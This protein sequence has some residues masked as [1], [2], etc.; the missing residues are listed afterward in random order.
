MSKCAR[1]GRRLGVSAGIVEDGE[2]F[3]NYECLE[4]LEG[5]RE[6]MAAH[7]EPPVPSPSH[8]GIVEESKERKLSRIEILSL[9]RFHSL[10]I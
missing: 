4:D 2:R 3:C 10:P 1:C 9:T 7:W 6:R 5:E 8:L